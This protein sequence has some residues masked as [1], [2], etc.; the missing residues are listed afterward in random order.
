MKNISKYMHSQAL[1]LAEVLIIL[2]GMYLPWVRV[3]PSHSGGV[4]DIHLS[5]METG[6][7]AFDL[8][9]LVPAVTLV[10]S[11]ILVYKHKLHWLIAFSAGIFYLLL[12]VYWESSIIMPPFVLDIGAYV[13]ATGGL[14][15]MFQ[16]IFNLIASDN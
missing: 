5:G 13:T 2:V 3:S 9:I 12:P 6:I 11:F 15:L 14:L 7:A 4:I 16:G 10:L 8:L 1:E